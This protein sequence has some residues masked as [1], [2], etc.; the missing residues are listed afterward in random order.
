MQDE[1]A[2]LYCQ[3]WSVLLCSIFPLYLTNDTI[4]ENKVIAHKIH[5]LIFCT[6]FL[7]TFLIIRR[8]YQKRASAFT[9]TTVILGTLQWNLNFIDGISKNTQIQNFSKILCRIVPSR[10]TERR[11]DMTKVT[12]AFRYF[13][14]APKGLTIKSIENIIC[15]Y[16]Q[17]CLRV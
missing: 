11:T 2:V 13:A 10:R 14:N 17:L 4:F 16:V 3:L 8:Y 5:V 15:M 12:I 9:Q 7:W 1:C 6:S